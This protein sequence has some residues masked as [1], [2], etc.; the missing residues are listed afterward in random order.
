MGMNIL[1]AFK[2]E[3]DLSMLS[4]ADWQSATGGWTGPDPA[5][6]PVAIGNDELGAAEMMLLAKEA[7][8]TLSLSAVT[9]GDTR[10]LATLRL[11]AALG[12]SQRTL[13]ACREDIRF[14]PAWVATQIAAVVVQHGAE[15]VLVGSQSSEGQNGQTGWLLAEMLGWPCLSQVVDFKRQGRGI[16]VQCESVQQRSLWQVEQP[17]VLI[18]QNRGQL[19]LRVPGMK[20]RLAAAKAE[21]ECRREIYTRREAL[22]CQ[23]LARQVQPRAGQILSEPATEAA[24]RL[25]REHLAARMHP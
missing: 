13:L 18:V 10:A 12:F 11:L 9:L 7:D 25:W 23:S 4:Q 22:N 17:V 20:A 21:I 2:A 24:Q 15:V 19:A 6:M 14:T 3:P 8:P 16:A 5:L 1:L